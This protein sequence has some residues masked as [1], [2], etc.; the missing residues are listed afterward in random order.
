MLS[1][2]QSKR[3]ELKSGQASVPTK[4][5]KY[6]DEMSF[7]LP[8]FKDRPTI[9]TVQYENYKIL[10]EDS[11]TVDNPPD[12]ETSYVSSEPMPAIPP[13]ID[14]QPLQTATP[15]RKRKSYFTIKTHRNSVNHTY[16][17]Y[18]RE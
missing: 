18:F 8:Y 9:C 14:S 11:G 6:E 1:V 2:V 3:Q 7:L 10:D 13:V 4:K 16:E 12:E 17:V 15:L 5:W